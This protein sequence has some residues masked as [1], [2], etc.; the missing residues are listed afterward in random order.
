MFRI[1]FKENQTVV[2]MQIVGRFTSNFAEEAK[3][4]IARRNMPADLVVDLSDVTFADSAGEET[5]SWL[6]GIGAK[7][8]AES[9]YALFLCERLGLPLSSELA[10]PF[11]KQASP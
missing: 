6:S 11:L 5:L 10:R 9:S 3:Q 8:I 2:T 4:L 1:S 7:F